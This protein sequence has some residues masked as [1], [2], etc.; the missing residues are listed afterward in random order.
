MIE[1]PSRAS[2][3]ILAMSMSSKMPESYLYV[4]YQRRPLPKGSCAL[5][6]RY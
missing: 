3:G 6:Y 2:T 5:I 4:K 1:A